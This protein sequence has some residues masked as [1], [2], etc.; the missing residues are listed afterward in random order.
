MANK[1][2]LSKE[3]IILTLTYAELLNDL[4][5]KDKAL[6]H[7]YNSM[8][9]TEFS[10]SEIIRIEDMILKIKSKNIGLRIEENFRSVTQFE[11]TIQIKKLLGRFLK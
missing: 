7:C 1:Q 6:T 9:Y 5:L 8:K 10:P 4:G 11:A 3:I 2:T